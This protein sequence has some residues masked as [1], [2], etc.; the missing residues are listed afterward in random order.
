MN[1]QAFKETLASKNP[2]PHP[3]AI[4]QA[5]WNYT[6]G[7]WDKGDTLRQHLPDKNVS[8][9]HAY[10]HRKEV[11]PQTVRW[12]KKAGCFFSGRMAANRSWLP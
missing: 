3:S 4:I 8:P 5:F 6:V 9:I 12:A 7:N 10:L 11:R 1:L 2:P